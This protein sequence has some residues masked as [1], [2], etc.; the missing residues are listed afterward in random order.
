M[1]YQN[2]MHTHQTPISGSAHSIFQPGFAGTNVQEV[3]YWNQG[4]HA[5]LTS[6]YGGSTSGF[7]GAQ[8][9]FQPG[10]AGTNAQEVRHQNQTSYAS[11]A[12]QAGYQQQPYGYQQAQTGYLPQYGESAQA[13]FSPGF[14]GTNVQEVQAR[15]H[16]GYNQGFN[17]GYTG[18]SAPISGHAGSIFSP[19]FAGTNAQEVRQ[20]NQGHS[21]QAAGFAS[22]GAGYGAIPAQQHQHMHTAP[23]G[24]SV[25]AVFHPSF[26]G[27]NAQEVRALNA[28][29]HA[30][31]TGSIYAGF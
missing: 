18:Y 7:A 19:G 25:Q 22:I 28:G 17:Q 27:T 12:P 16:T 20:L 8:A 21:P 30:P 1:T 31:Y 23:L 4:G 26:A 13:V 5:P 29:Q 15:N 11:F 24:S 10:F 9:I 2:M 14:A 3:R 6:T